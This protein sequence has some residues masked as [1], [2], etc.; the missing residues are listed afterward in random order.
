[1][2]HA[3]ED[4]EA[5]NRSLRLQILENTEAF[6]RE[7]EMLVNERNMVITR[8]KKIESVIIQCY[9]IVIVVVVYIALNP[10]ISFVVGPLTGWSTWLFFLH[11]LVVEYIFGEISQFMHRMFSQMKK[12]IGVDITW[13]GLPLAEDD[14]RFQQANKKISAELKSEIEELNP[15]NCLRHASRESDGTTVQCDE[16][17]VSEAS[18]SAHAESNAENV[19]LRL[20]PFSHWPNYPLLVRR[21]P[22]MFQRPSSTA[23][24]DQEGSM[25]AKDEKESI[26]QLIEPLRI[27]QEPP[28]SA[29]FAVDNHLFQG[30]VFVVVAGVQDSPVEFFKNKNRLFEVVVQGRFKQRTPFCHVYN[31]QLFYKPFDNLPPKWM[32]RILIKLLSKIQPGLQVSMSGKNP[33]IVS[34]LIAASK[35]VVVSI[36]GSEPDICITRANEFEAL[37]EDMTLLASTAS[38]CDDTARNMFNSRSSSRRAQYFSKLENLSKFSYSPDHVYTFDFYQH[39]LNIGQMSLD[40][41]FTSLDVSKIIGFSPVQIMAVKWDPN[42]EPDMEN[43]EYFYNIEMWNRK[44]IPSD[45]FDVK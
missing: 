27:H 45:F 17:N 4:L 40:L 14:I 38:A 1:M 26:E 16:D 21:S 23:P 31:G 24:H 10:L 42:S 13:L 19:T 11:L 34:S 36:P 12:Y 43:I 33:Y 32:L 6:E 41:G 5:E 3:I 39:V 8:M 20:P 29:V 30:K 44:C 18:L 28:H 7:R 2:L 37:R 15:S 22:R 25:D 35:H 9:R